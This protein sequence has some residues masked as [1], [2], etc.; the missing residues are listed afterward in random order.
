MGAHVES[1]YL[2]VFKEDNPT[3]FAPGLFVFKNF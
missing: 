3:E 1:A 2:F